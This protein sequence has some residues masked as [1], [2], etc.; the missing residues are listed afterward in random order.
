M[1]GDEAAMEEGGAPSAGA[2]SSS[3]EKGKKLKKVMSHTPMEIL[4][5]VV[6][7][8]T[9][10]TS[11]SAMVLNPITPVFLAGALSSVIGSYAYYQQ[12]KLTGTVALKE[13]HEA[14][15]R[16]RDRLHAKNVRLNEMIGELSDSIENLEGVRQALDVITKTQGQSVAVF[17]EQVKEN[18]D[19]LG[20]MQKNLKASVLQNLLQVVFRSDQDGNNY[21]EGDEI[22]DLISRIQKISG[23][24]VKEDRF[25]DM[26]VSHGGAVSSVMD[27]IKILMANNVSGEG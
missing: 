2:S 20:Q 10:G 9:V 17:A 23:A 24:D 26:I 5:G 18:R 12:T 16:E 11:V 25:K 27:I 14:V 21:I 15:K 6:A 8:V 4:S 7:A 19:I 13:T 22:D 3:S 1:S